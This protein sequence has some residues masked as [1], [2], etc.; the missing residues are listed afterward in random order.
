[1]SEAGVAATLEDRGVVVNE[2]GATLG[3]GE[4]GDLL[5]SE[6]LEEGLD[7]RLAVIDG[8]AGEL[9]HPAV[10]EGDDSGVVVARVG[11]L[12]EGIVEG[13]FAEG[14]SVLGEGGAP[15]PREGAGGDRGPRNRLRAVRSCLGCSG[16]GYT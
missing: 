10:A 8:K 12:P 15:D 3:M 6:L 14:V 1:V 16:K 5:N 4:G 9:G 2:V 7:I 13:L 11:V